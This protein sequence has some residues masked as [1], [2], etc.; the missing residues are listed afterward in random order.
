MVRARAPKGPSPCPVCGVLSG[1]VHDYYWRTMAD[2]PVDGRR[3][4][5]LRVRVRR[6]VC[7][8]WVPP[9]L[10]TSARK[11]CSS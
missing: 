10:P 1:Q 2:V 11:L 8:T 6:L 5:V 3:R 7:P 9:D 4:V